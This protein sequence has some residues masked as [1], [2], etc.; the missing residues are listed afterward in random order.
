MGKRKAWK[1]EEEDF[2]I[3]NYDFMG[4]TEIAETLKR[5]NTSISLKLYELRDKKLINYKSRPVK[6]NKKRLPTENLMEQFKIKVENSEYITMLIGTE[7]ER[8]KVLD[9]HNTYFTVQR[10]NYRESYQYT[11]LLI[12]AIKLRG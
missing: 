1:Q 4:T 6:Y 11:D 8:V 7:T 10:Q 5:T 9:T 2:I 3:K 12:G